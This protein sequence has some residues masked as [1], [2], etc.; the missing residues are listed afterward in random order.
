M[1]PVEPRTLPRRRT[2]TS[3]VPRCS[4]SRGETL[5]DALGESEDADGI[6]GFVG[7][8]LNEARDAGALAGADQGAGCEGVDGGGGEGVLLGLRDVLEGG[9]VEDDVGPEGFEEIEDK[10]GV[11]DVGLDGVDLC[12][13]YA[14][15]EI[16]QG[17][18]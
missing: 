8:E 15:I 4:A 13:R 5:G 9:C 16:R 18:L 10:G 12:R 7:G 1:L 14:V 3:R 11:A 6:D 2:L 17:R